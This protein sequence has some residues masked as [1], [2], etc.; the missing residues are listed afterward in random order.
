MFF[1]DGHC[2]TLTKALDLNKGVY[3]N[4]LQFSIKEANKIGGGIQVLA[5]FVESCY[6]ETKNEFDKFEYNKDFPF[7]DY[8][9]SFNG[10]VVYDVINKNFLYKK[11]IRRHNNENCRNCTKF[12]FIAL[13]RI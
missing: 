8:I 5:C 13:L 7:I 3:E 4:D 1:I 2:D 12:R 9:V 6:L 11:N 10:A